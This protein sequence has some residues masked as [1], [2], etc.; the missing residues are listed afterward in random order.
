MDEIRRLIRVA[1]RRNSAEEYTVAKFRVL[2]DLNLR[3]K[4]RAAQDGLSPPVIFE[5]MMRG[6]VNQ[7]PAVLAMLDQWIRDNLPEYKEPKTPRLSASDLEEIYAVADSS[8][9]DEE[10]E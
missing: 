9:I 1:A 8:M 4:E 7:H 10:I 3:F 2:K 6:Y 5:A